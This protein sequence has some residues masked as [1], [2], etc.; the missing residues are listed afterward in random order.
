MEFYEPNKQI[1]VNITNHTMTFNAVITTNEVDLDYDTLPDWWEA[2]N[3]L[4]WTNPADRFTD[5]DGDWIENRWEF[6]LGLDPNSSNANNYAFADAM[7]AI[8]SRVAGTNPTN[9]IRIFAI[10]DHANT[11]YIRN[12]NCWAAGIDLTCCSPWNS[13]L[14]HKKAGTLISPRHVLFAAHY[15]VAVGETMHFVDSDN[16][17]ILRTLI[18][19]KTH[20]DCIPWYPDLTVGLLNADVPTNTITFTAV[21][22]DDYQNY[23]GAGEGIPALCLDQEEKALIADIGYITSTN[24]N[25]RITAFKYPFISDRLLY[26]EKIISGDSGNPAFLLLDNNPVLL[27]VWSYEGAGWGTSVTWFKSDINQMMADL[28]EQYNGVTNGYQLIEIDLSGFDE[29]TD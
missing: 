1:R 24:E 4:S 19:T 28:D 5:F 22:P 21:L 10:K 3:G 6:R 23:L 18:G 27:T 29:L 25:N 14:Y 2:I 16:N 26:S 15:P 17:A 7:R 11:N 12:T 20:P 13:D 9:A 8:D